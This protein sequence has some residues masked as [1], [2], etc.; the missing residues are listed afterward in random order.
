MELLI[1]L[2]AN[3]NLAPGEKGETALVE[4]CSSGQI[5][6][7]VAHNCLKTKCFIWEVNDLHHITH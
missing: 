3:I 2:N 7:N 4:A 1:K 5:E 6:L